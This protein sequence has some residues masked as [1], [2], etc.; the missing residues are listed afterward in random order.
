NQV[1]QPQRRAFQGHDREVTRGLEELAMLQLLIDA[2]KLIVQRAPAELLGRDRSAAALGAVD[3]DGAGENLEDQ[4]ELLRRGGRVGLR[5]VV[6]ELLRGGALAVAQG[7]G[8]QDKI[9][10]HF[11]TLNNRLV[12][13]TQTRSHALRGNAVLAALR[14]RHGGAEMPTR[15]VEDGI[16]TRS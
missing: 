15:S 4:P 7:E 9:Q 6:V 1:P 11:F 3:L 10:I 12:C 14:P 2:L 13:N 5:E 16:P 8:G